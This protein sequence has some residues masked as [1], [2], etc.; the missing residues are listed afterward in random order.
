MFF[1]ADLPEDVPRVEA[2]ACEFQVNSSSTFPV[3]FSLITTEKLQYIH[4]STERTERQADRSTNLT[5]LGKKL[6][7]FWTGSILLN[8][9]SETYGTDSKNR[10]QEKNFQ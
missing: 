9:A 7:Q 2:N 3:N 8:A 5:H 10:I 1:K 4:L 6:N